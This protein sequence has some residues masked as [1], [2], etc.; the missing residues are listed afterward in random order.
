M[1]AD[2]SGEET[3]DMIA[4]LPDRLLS[5]AKSEVIGAARAAAQDLCRHGAAVIEAARNPSRRVQQA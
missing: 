5:Y 3:G 1:A 4:A 2:I